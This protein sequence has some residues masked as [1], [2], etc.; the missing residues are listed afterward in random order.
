MTDSACRERSASGSRQAGPTPSGTIDEDVPVTTERFLTLGAAPGP[1]VEVLT[2][3]ATL[4]RV[5]VACGDGQRRNVVLGHPDVEERLASGDYLGST[6]GRYANRI[7]GGRFVLDGREV[8]VGTHDRG[9]SLHGGPDGF[10]RRVWDVVSHSADEVVLSLVSPDGDQGFPGTV[11]A[12]ATYR[13]DGDTVSVEMTATTDA[14]TVVNLTNHAYLN[15]DGEGAGTVD[16]HELV[17]E[18]DEVTPVDA[19]GIPL[20]GHTPVVGTPFDLRSPTR[21]GDAV[22]A[23]HPQVLDARGIDHNY[24]VRGSGLRRAAALSSARTATRVELWTDQPGLQ[25]YTGNFLDGTRLGTSGGRYRQGDG[26][27]LEP[28]LFPD[29]PNRPEWP[30]AVLRPGETYR[31]RVEWRFG[32]RRVNWA[33]NIAYA[34]LDVRHPGSVEELQEVV[35]GAER[36]RASGSGHS[37]NTLVDTDRTLVSTRGLPREVVVDAAAGEAVVA[38][39][40]TYA[41]VAPLL[42]EAGWALPNTGSLPHISLGGATATGTHGSGVG[43]GCLATSVTGIELVTAD[44]SLLRVREGEADFPGAVLSLGS[45]GVATR[46]WLRLEPTYDVAQD[47]LLDVPTTAVVEDG[48]ALMSSAHS[49]SLFTT[50]GT[51]GRLDSVWRKARVD[52]PAEGDWG[53]RPAEVAVHPIPRLAADAATPQL[54][55]PGPWHERLPH[56][57]ADHVPSVGD[58]LQSEFFL[59]L[60]DLPRAWPVIEALSPRLAGALQVMEI[61]AIAADTMW[62]SPFR[63]R[64]SVA[65]HVTWVS[66][67]DV[68]RP[69]LGALEDALAPFDPRPHWAKV[70]TRWDRDRFAAAYPGLGDFRALADRLDPGRCFTNDF[71]ERL[72]VR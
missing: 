35:A 51:P 48:V 63:D 3:G 15:L 58:E 16:D 38:A 1:V 34:T 72:G 67:L 52:A 4:H 61:R 11:T 68:V 69:A 70:F 56:F 25:V 7:A 46:L 42:H 44:G 36:V 39:G 8:E 43:N 30:S 23:D 29:S 24:V 71:V 27:A 55:V 49:V 13:V 26:V 57:R 2:L 28:Q 41:E 21:I 53:G 19:T 18:A 45:L 50:F 12:T 62:L 47:V 66:D 10:D 60:E 37:F 65:V 64:T 59:A 33:G 22:R 40:M 5:V 31:S 32:A 20:G 17:V 9:H 14:A 6:I 54:G